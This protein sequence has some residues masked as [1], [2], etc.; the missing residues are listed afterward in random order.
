MKKPEQR[1]FSA[2]GDLE[3]GTSTPIALIYATRPRKL[4]AALYW[5]A[6]GLSLPTP[7]PGHMRAGR[8]GG[9]SGSSVCTGWS[10]CVRVCVCVCGLCLSNGGLAPV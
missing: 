10:E 6:Y 3:G 2:L 4:T 7:Q 8:G 5:I 1:A 9:W